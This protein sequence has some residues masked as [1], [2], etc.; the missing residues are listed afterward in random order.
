MDLET[1]FLIVGGLVSLGTFLE[2][3]ANSYKTL[4]EAETQRKKN[5]PRKRKR[6][7]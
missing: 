2:K 5:A 4:I 3:L 6:S 1:I 7:R